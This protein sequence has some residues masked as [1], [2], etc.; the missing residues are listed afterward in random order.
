M[1]ESGMVDAL[2]HEGLYHFRILTPVLHEGT[3]E[4][5]R[6][7]RVLDLGWCKISCRDPK[8]SEPL[9]SHVISFLANLTQIRRLFEDT[10]TGCQL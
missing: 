1:K 9:V 8:F 3:R 5:P 6:D 2:E 7:G 4:G 10:L